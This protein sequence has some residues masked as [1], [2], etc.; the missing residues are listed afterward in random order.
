[1]EVGRRAPEDH[2]QLARLLNVVDTRIG[3]EDELTASPKRFATAASRTRGSAA[4]AARRSRPKSCDRPSGGSEAPPNC[5]CSTRPTGTCSQ[6][7]SDD[8]SGEDALRHLVRSRHDDRAAVLLQVLVRRGEEASEQPGRNFVAV[9]DPGTLME[10]M[11]KDDRFRT[12]FLNPAEHR[13]RYSA[14][15]FFGLVPAALQVST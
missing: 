9:T 11:A 6:S 10:K 5:S 12:I 2:P 7:S 15:S 4:W 13:E 1:M 8:R 14:L 3:R